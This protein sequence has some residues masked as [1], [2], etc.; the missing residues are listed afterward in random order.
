MTAQ[1]DLRM[2]NNSTRPTAFAAWSEGLP[3]EG[4]A[5]FWPAVVR[6]WP[7]FDRIDHRRYARL[8]RRFRS[9]RPASF[10]E[11]LPDQV[12]IY[13]GQDASDP[14]GLAW[15]TDRQVAE[16]FADGHRGIVPDDPCVYEITVDR[17]DVAFSCDD[18][19]EREIV[20]LRVTPEMVR[21]ALDETV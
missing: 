8:F 12:R 9:S 1:P 11:H 21:Q 6:E 20:L 16:G 5:D 13:R 4:A 7:G 3:A 15:T 19:G 2:H 17:M 10:I 18:R 14:F